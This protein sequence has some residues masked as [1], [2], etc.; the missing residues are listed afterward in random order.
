MGKIIVNLTE[1]NAAEVADEDLLAVE[2]VDAPKTKSLSIGELRKTILKPRAVSGD[3]IALKTILPENIDYSTVTKDSGGQSF[4]VQIGTVLICSGMNPVANSGTTITFPKAFAGTP[5]V[6]ATVKD[7]NNQTA[8]V[9]D[10]SPTTAILK[11]I[12]TGNPLPVCWIAMGK[13]A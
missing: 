13:A 11:Q 3:S 7:P 9:T 4:Y 1:M 6:T 2:D 10:I 5:T 8:W 12:W